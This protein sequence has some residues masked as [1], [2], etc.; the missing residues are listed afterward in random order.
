MSETAHE[1]TNRA[2]AGT[3]RLWTIHPRY[4]DPRGLVA[5]WR[6]ALLARKVL[7]GHTRGYRNHPQLE[8]FLAHAEPMSVIDSYLAAVHGE[9]ST[10]G[11][12]FD[13]GKFERV[14][15]VPALTTTSGQVAYEWDHLLRK[16]AGRNAEFHSRW[17]SL[18]TP[19]CHPLFT[20]VPGP[21][22]SWERT[23]PDP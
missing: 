22:E 5:L 14:E 6:E 16:L 19:G 3:M 17:C 10:R 18:S 1:I 2:V 9:A 23:T 20:E 21:V 4:L 13:P 7:Q 15:L 12:S 8:R 11:Y